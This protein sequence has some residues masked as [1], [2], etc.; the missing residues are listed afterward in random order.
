[1][2][3]SIHVENRKRI[4]LLIVLFCISLFAF[5]FLVES[6]QEI[7]RGEWQIITSPS[8]LITDYIALS[9]L[10]AALFNVALVTCIALGMAWFIR[11]RFNGYFLAAIFTLVGFSFFGT[12]PFNIL[13]LFLGVYLY[14]RVSHIQMRDLIAPLLFGTTLAPVVSQTAFGF[15]LGGWGLV[16]GI[17][18]GMIA[19][20]LLAGLMKHIYTFH[21]GYNLYNT[22]TTGGFVATVVYMMMRG[23]GLEIKPAFYW[24]TEYTG[25]LSWWLLV[26]MMIM[27]LL[28]FFWGA[29]ISS[30]KTILRCWG[31][32]TS[33]YVEI[34]DLGTTLVNMGVVGLIGL[35]YVHLVD[36]DVNGATLAGIFTIFAFGA[37]GKHPRNILP[38]MVGVYLICIPKIWNHNEAGP[39]L[40]ALFCTTLAPLAGR[41]GILAGILAGAL[42]LP[43]VMHVGSMHG[44]MNLYNNGFAG[45]LTMMLIIGLI[46]GLH[47]EWLR[48]PE[49]IPAHTPVM[50]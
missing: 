27:I 28:G 11:A 39:L 45:G 9:N 6:P 8:I 30:Y 7:L 19:G 49:D 1:M 36:G 17:L 3:T 42:H 4:T 33:D 21:Q 35:A 37:L 20:F 38:I 46:N 43:M 40:A 5:A 2:E 32:L 50:H 22:G 13:P 12:N 41:F 23:F 47:P 10:G 14:D 25:L 48:E 29:K 24:S 15:D 34:T 16:L 18:L 26:F 31:S 44:F